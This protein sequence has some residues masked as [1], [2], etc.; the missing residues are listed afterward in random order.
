M[1]TTVETAAA[2]GPFHVEFS[3]EQIED[4]RQLAAMQEL[5]RHR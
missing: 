1:S 2:T 3:K 4:L 5:A